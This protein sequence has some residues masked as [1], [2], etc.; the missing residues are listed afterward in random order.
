MTG[1]VLP[2]CV[3]IKFSYLKEMANVCSS[4]TWEDEGEGKDYC[5][6][7]ANLSYTA[8]ICP[9]AITYQDPVSKNNKH[10]AHSKGQGA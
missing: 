3:I 9:G 8:S 5:D 7:Q 1:P 6:F 10:G 4:S 2:L